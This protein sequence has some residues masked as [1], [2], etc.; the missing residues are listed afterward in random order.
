MIYEHVE[1]NHKIKKKYFLFI[2]KFV[3]RPKYNQINLL[4]FSSVLRKK[5]F[6]RN[7]FKLISVA[8]KYNFVV[9]LFLLFFYY[10]NEYRKPL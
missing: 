3:L 6:V 8:G 5:R 10:L 1:G 7:I 4:S 2:L 9:V